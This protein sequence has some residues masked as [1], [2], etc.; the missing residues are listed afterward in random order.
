MRKKNPTPKTYQLDPQNSRLHPADNR[1]LIDRSLQ[2]VGGFRSIAVD[3]DG[4]VRAGNGVFSRASAL[5]FEFV[6]VEIKPNQILVA[7]RPDLRGRA[8]E[9]AALYD[10][11]AS[12]SSLNDE[13]V[14][15]A[16]LRRDRDMLDDIF[17]ANDI[18][19]LMDIKAAEPPQ[20]EDGATFTQAQIEQYNVVAGQVWEMP[21]VST[22]G[23][24]RLFVGDATLVD[25]YQALLGDQRAVGAFTSP[26]YAEQRKSKYGGEAEANYVAW[27]ADVQAHTKAFLVDDGNFFV[28][29]KA[30]ARQGERATY[31]LD[32]VL[33]MGREWGWKYVDDFV[34]VKPG[35]PGDMGKRFKNGHEPIY[36]FAKSLNYAFHIEQ[37][38][39]TRAANFKG[40]H[41]N[42]ETIQGARSER[43]LVELDTVRPSNVLHLAPD[44]TA[45]EEVAFHPARF[46]VELPD[47]F[48][49]AF[50]RTGELWLDMFSGSGTFIVA[51]EQAGR[52]GY[53]IER[54]LRYVAGTLARLERLTGLAPRLVEDLS[55]RK[56]SP[57]RK[58]LRPT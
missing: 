39:E 54:D 25:S 10:N 47:F 13:A 57:R 17:T 29:L 56:K 40:Y 55:T 42:L 26:P 21:S 35:Y 9:R 58:K 33:A 41:E 4:I 31:S 3:G 50:S 52:L 7:V 23:C 24:H 5:G 32:L 19:A 12:D 22:G 51:C 27:W 53:G 34:W 43:Q 20:H 30:H 8:A 44:R 14:L 18:Q 38:V 28:N 49:R 11:A 46:P 16:I 15:R 1:N 48:L 36:Q 6:P 45:L 2:E 37:V